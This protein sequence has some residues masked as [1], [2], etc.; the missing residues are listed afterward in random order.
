MLELRGLGKSFGPGNPLLD[1]VD[2]QVAAGEWV[3]IVGESGSGKST[4]LNL[5]AGLDRPDRGEVRLG[6][7]ALDY[8]DDDALSLW[9]RNA[10]GFVFQAFHLLPYL[11]VVQNV[12]LPLAL[13]GVASAERDARATAQ[14]E[15]VGL[16]GFGAR[17]PSTLSGGEMQRAAIARALVHRPGLLL[18]DEPTGNLDTANAGAVLDCLADAVKR[19]GAA[20]LM[21]THSPVAAARA[22]RV[23]RLAAGKLVP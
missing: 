8:A 21:V 10:V 20:A 3:A 6:G 11:S 7:R 19:A 17:R 9:R 4:L 18:A 23:L 14:L 12:A 1:A 16:A 5:V 22:D 13:L 15:A 2:L